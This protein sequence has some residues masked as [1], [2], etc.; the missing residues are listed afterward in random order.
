MHYVI[1][2]DDDTFAF[3][4]PACLERIYRP[5]LDMGM[6]VCLAT[7][8]EART[9]VR[10]PDGLL[11][12][13][14]TSGGGRDVGL[15]PIG[16]GRGLVD[17]IQAEACYD[18]VQHGCHH[19]IFEFGG[20][21]RQELAR[22]LDRGARALHDAGFQKP[23]AFVAPY[24]RMSRAA[25]VEVSARFAVISTGWFE[26]GRVPARWWVAYALRKLGRK[27]HWSAGGCH[28]LSHP[29]CLL[30]YHRDRAGMMDS[31]RAAVEG[32]KLTVLVSHWWEFFRGGI[33]D[34]ELIA[35]I[36][37]VADWISSR[38]DIQVVT[39]SDVAGGRVH[40]N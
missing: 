18:V 27:R 23:H 17:Y 15:A 24:D 40:L 26:A 32:S 6:P 19:D 39:F 22:R 20:S 31:V 4:P 1:I 5:F 36:H 30:S 2:R 37:E 21:D 38:P 34:V 29:G 28:L 7:I 8:P 9:N 25:F 10:T 12:G 35:K 14:L 13:Y 16:L 11:E 33:P 3:T